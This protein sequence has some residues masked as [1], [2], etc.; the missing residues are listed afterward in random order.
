[1]TNN[2]IIQ[3]LHKLQ[4]KIARQEESLLQLGIGFCGHCG[5]PHKLSAPGHRVTYM[6]LSPK[7]ADRASP[8]I[9]CMDDYSNAHCFFQMINKKE[10][11]E[12]GQLRQVKYNDLSGSVARW[13]LNA[14]VYARS[15]KMHGFL[16]Q[17]MCD[18][19]GDVD[20]QEFAMK[21]LYWRNAKFGGIVAGETNRQLLRMCGWEPTNEEFQSVIDH[22]KVYAAA[23]GH[24]DQLKHFSR[25]TTMEAA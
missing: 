16:Q 2:Q 7:D 18:G 8:L 11:D 22:C 13:A 17:I 21:L 15:H 23:H 3:M 4:N 12:E 9:V 6:T 5:K 14:Q 24:A 19:F 1:M 10:E 25:I 20:Y